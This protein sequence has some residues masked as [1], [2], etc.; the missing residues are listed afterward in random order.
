MVTLINDKNIGYILA[1]GEFNVAVD[2]DNQLWVWGRNEFG[3]V[4]QGHCKIRSR[5]LIDNKNMTE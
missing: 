2:S 5:S 3:Q 1:G 4:G